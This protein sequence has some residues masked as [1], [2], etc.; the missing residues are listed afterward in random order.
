AELGVDCG[1]TRADSFVYT[2]KPETVETLEREAEAAAEAGLPATYVTDVD[3]DVPAI[4]AVKFASQAHFHPRR[5]L[6]ALADEIEKAGGKIVEGVRAE[7]VDELGGTRVRTSS[8]E[9]RAGE[10]VVATHY[11]VFDRGLYFARLDP[12]RDLV[13][14]G[15]IEGNH[16]PQGMFLDADTHHSVR[17]YLNEGVPYTIVGGEHYRVGDSV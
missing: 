8:G 5:W 12:V 7:G 4:G 11:P 9:V 17:S 10:V 2:T 15:P 16:A 13:V 14:A 6:L 1:F 3:L